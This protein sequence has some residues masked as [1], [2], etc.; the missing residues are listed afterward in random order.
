MLELVG[1]LSKAY[2]NSIKQLDWMGDETKVK[3]LEKLGKFT[4]KIGYP[5]IWK[6]YSKL[7]INSTDLFGNIVRSNQ[8]TYDWEVAKLGGP[9]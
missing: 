8:V 4:P 2:E 1:N 6:D 9:I 7:E 3:A 5:D